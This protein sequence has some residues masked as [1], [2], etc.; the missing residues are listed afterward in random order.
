MRFYMCKTLPNSSIE[1][2]TTS[3][4]LKRFLIRLFVWFLITFEWV[5]YLC[6]AMTLKKWISSSESKTPTSVWQTLHETGW[7]RSSLSLSAISASEGRLRLF[8]LDLE[9]SFFVSGFDLCFFRPRRFF[10]TFFLYRNTSPLFTDVFMENM[11]R[12]CVW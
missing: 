2:I 10:G 11:A 12:Y 7:K 6:E 8:D 4:I 3:L 9:R 5:I 1:L